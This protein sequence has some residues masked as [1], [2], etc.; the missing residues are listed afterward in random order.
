MSSI[1]GRKAPLMK[2]QPCNIVLEAMQCIPKYNLIMATAVGTPTWI[3]IISQG[4]TPR[5]KTTGN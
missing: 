5:E 2:P 3:P 4:P 1:Y